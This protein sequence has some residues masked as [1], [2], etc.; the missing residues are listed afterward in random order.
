MP[1][2]LERRS[3]E[4]VAGDV[5][6][7]RATEPD[8]RRPRR[9]YAVQVAHYGSILAAIGAG[10]G[11]EAFVIGRDRRSVTYDLAAPW[12]RAGLSVAGLTANLTS[13]ARL[14][15]DRAVP[16]LGATSATC[17][18]CHWH[19]VCERE[20]AAADDAT[21]VAGIGRAARDA[22]APYAPTVAALAALDIAPLANGGGRT[23][24]AGIGSER[25]SRFR[26]RARL[27]R[28]PGATAYAMR[29]L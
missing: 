3:G 22:L 27:L 29:P 13:R 9:E 26:N 16:T 24:V 15:R 20:L 8:G 17:K 4:W 1:D 28:T 19:S 23:V 11:A 7:G 5:K 2:V 6:S 18:M 14:I 25:L 12:D 10:S 21:L